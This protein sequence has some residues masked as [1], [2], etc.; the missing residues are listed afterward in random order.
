MRKRGWGIALLILLAGALEL[1]PLD[2]ML[3][4][5]FFDFASGRWWVDGQAQWGRSL[6]YTGPKALLIAV[7]ASLIA[8]VAGP[9]S[10]RRALSA[11]GWL[12]A[13]PRLLV[14]FVVAASVPLTVGAL[15]NVSGVFCPSELVR[16]GG[17][18]PYRRPF[19]TELCASGEGH[20]WPAGHASGGFALLALGLLAGDTRRHRQT[21]VAALVVGWTM[22]LYQMWKGAHFASHTVVTILLAMIAVAAGE[23]VMEV[24]EMRRVLVDPET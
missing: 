16:Y 24:G 5:C 2:L 7:A 20:C 6:F 13:R 3:Q 21:V 1:T 9:A 23:V 8:L 4:D 18:A 22:G 11:R 17:T 19:S 14:A 15:K 10:W 12:T